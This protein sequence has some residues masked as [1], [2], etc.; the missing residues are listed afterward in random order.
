LALTVFCS[1]NFFG[2]SKSK[3]FGLYVI[4]PEGY[5]CAVSAAAPF[6]ENN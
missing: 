4:V 5:Q 1:E 3:S 6:R 2:T